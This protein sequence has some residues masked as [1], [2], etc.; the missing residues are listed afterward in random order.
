ML[1]GHFQAFIVIRCRF[2]R[3]IRRIVHL[4]MARLMACGGRR[5]A[6]DPRIFRASTEARPWSLWGKTDRRGSDAC[7]PPLSLWC[8]ASKWCHLLPAF[9]EALE[10]REVLKNDLDRWRWC[11]R[12]VSDGG[13]PHGFHTND[14]VKVHHPAQP[15]KTRDAPMPMKSTID[16]GTTM[17]GTFWKNNLDR[18]RRYGK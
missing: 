2:G 10:F 9:A 11:G 15:R 12:G 7:S 6:P 8:G 13:I 5:F 17:A 16:A 4:N 18:Q 1:E 3:K 14:W